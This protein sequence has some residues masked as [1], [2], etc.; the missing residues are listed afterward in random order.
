MSIEQ[1]KAACARVMKHT[2]GP[3]STKFGDHPTGPN[4]HSIDIVTENWPNDDGWVADVHQQFTSKENGW[5]NAKLIAAAPDMLQFI[6]D[7]I[8]EYNK[9]T[10]DLDPLYNQAALLFDK[11]TK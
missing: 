5:A 9:A 11:A 2:P 6:S 8:T 7:F 10:I 1:A 4:N 3:W